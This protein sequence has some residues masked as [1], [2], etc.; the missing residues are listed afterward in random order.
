MVAV[1]KIM[2]SDVVTLDESKTVLDACNLFRAKKIGS[3][4]TLKAGRATG[5]LTERD[6]V[7]RVVCTGKS[8]GKTYLKDVMSSP[9]LT[10]DPLSSMEW[11]SQM[12]IE[13][14]VKKLGVVEKGSLIGVI[15]A[16]D[17]V[18]AEPKMYEEFLKLWIPH[19]K[20]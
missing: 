1:V 8:A 6:V 5:I 3:V 2:T 16:T 15:T 9:L 4:I 11:A 13:N 14:K 20:R 10:I 19:F 7:E 17:I 12:M 18:R